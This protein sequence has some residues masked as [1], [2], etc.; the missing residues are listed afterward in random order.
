MKNGGYKMELMREFKKVKNPDPNG[1]R[2]QRRAAKK[3]LQKP[4]K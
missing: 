3:M 1:N 4:T 2:R